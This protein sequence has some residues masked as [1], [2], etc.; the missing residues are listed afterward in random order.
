MGTDRKTGRK[1]E[2]QRQE[3]EDD[4]GER[5]VSGKWLNEKT[6]DFW[7]SHWQPFQ[8]LKTRTHMHTHGGKCLLAVRFMC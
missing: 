4:E 8:E 3:A 1:E 5:G 7:A 2:V 6:S